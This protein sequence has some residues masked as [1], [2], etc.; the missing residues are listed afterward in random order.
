MKNGFRKKRNKL[1]CTGGLLSV[2]AFSLAACG[3]AEE[4]NETIVF[5]EPEWE[6][7]WFHNSVAQIIAEEGYGYATETQ[8]G[9]SPATLQG[10][11]DGDIDVY[12]ETWIENMQEPY[13]E[14]MDAGEIVELSTN[15]DDNEQGLY[16]PTFVIEGDEEEG[17]EPMAPDLESVGDLEEYWEVFEDPDE[18]G[19]GRIYGSPPGYEAETI[20]DDMYEE[21]GLNE[22]YNLFS[23][24]SE[25]ALNTSLLTAYEDGEPWIGY[26][27]EPTW[28][29]GL[30]DM[31]LL[32]EEDPDDP[33]FPSQP[34]TVTANTE[35]A[36]ND[37]EFVAFL[38]QYETSSDIT[39]EALHYMEENDADEWEAAEWF[40][41][42]YE[43]LWTEWV[44]EDVAE[45]VLASL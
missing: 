35:F 11:R 42:E 10:L 44:P 28:I 27:W 25:A 12:L 37:E 2:A 43:D 13:Q 8:T 18:D 5:A 1:W 23:P 34:V 14:G 24:G 38:E 3:G 15:F 32:E 22:N 16:V 7:I 6:S 4:D 36:E 33:F 30:L 21:A 40:L 45:D 31:T 9:S 20:V 19:I 17:I 29:I 26:N 41:E 39:G